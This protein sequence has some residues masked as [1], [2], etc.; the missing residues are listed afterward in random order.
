MSGPG[1]RAWAIAR[2]LSTSFDVTAAVEE[3]PAESR[4]GIR[5]VPFTRRHLIEQVKDQ[6]AVISSCVPPYLLPLAATGSTL[7]VA[8]KYDPVD[9]EV[10]ALTDSLQI[11]RALAT[12]RAVTELHLLYSD[13]VLC[14]N[15]RQRERI[16]ARI[17]GLGRD[18]DGPELIELPF[19]LGDPPPPPR[20]RPLRERFTQIA[21]GDT[22]VLWWGV[23]WKWLDAE[24]AV[25]AVAGLADQRPDIKLV[26]APARTL[27][28]AAEATNATEQARNLARDLG[29]LDR[30]VLFWDDWVPFADRHELLAEADIGLSLHSAT[31]EAHFSARVR[32]LDYL[33]AG[34]PCVLAEGDETGERFQAAGF[35]SL[36]PPEDVTA[37]QTELTRLADDRDALACARKASLALADS[38]RWET[39]VAPLA[40]TLDG[41]PAAAPGKPAGRALRVGRYYAR[42]AVDKALIAWGE[43]A[44]RAR[45]R[46]LPDQ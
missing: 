34:L 14:A 8:D 18:Q 6:H 44:E 19:G 4:E 25:R 12:E 10:G 40:A 37:V 45:C 23:V 3:P 33:W 24:T 26:F 13:I 39:L 29:V 21:E 35:A 11:R 15:E 38:Y 5:L 42:R 30:T 2:A 41:N 32:Y 31:A 7:V 22:V 27:G 20:G 16:E 43:V 46:P 28:A 17:R 1:I 36:V 9:L